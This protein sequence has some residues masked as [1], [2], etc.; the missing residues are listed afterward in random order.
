MWTRMDRYRPALAPDGGAAGGSGDTAATAAAAAAAAAAATAG[1]AKGAAAAPWYGDKIDE[2]TRGFWQNKGI[3]ANDPIAVAT[4]LTEFYR[5]SEKFIGAPPEEMIRVPKANAPEADIRAYWGRIGVPAEAKD[6]DLSTVKFADGKELGPLADVL[7]T[8]LLDGRV[9]K[10][11]AAQVAQHI[12]KHR[13]AEATAALAEKTAVIKTEREA[14]DKNWGPNKPYNEQIAKRALEDLGNAAGLDAGQTKAAWD[15]I[16][17]VGG[18]G[19]SYAMEMLRTI[20]ARLNTTPAGESLFVA[21][22]AGQSNQV[23]SQAQAKAR[24]DELKM[25][26]SFYKRLVT[27]KEVAARREWD[28]LHKIAF[29]PAA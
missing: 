27:D 18:I 26:R 22:G 17:T 16:S 8:A 13:E 15:A 10:D 7:R 14:L 29:R 28:D 1:A 20:G 25:D 3:D 2:V 21:G 24:I 9:P 4:K 19:A 23:M 5:N 11:R 6:Y 12:V